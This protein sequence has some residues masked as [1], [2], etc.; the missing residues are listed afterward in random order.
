MISV[1]FV[2]LLL[3]STFF[4]KSVSKNEH[5]TCFCME[6]KHYCLTKYILFFVFD[7]KMLVF[8]LD[9]LTKC[10]NFAA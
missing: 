1:F 2:R 10:Y 5:K 3:F 8:L 4:C 6:K 9:I 7:E